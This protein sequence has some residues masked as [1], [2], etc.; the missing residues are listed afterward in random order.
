MTQ[1][2]F[3]CSN[4][5]EVLI[6]RCGAIVEDLGKARDR[7]ASVVRS[8]TTARSREDWRRWILHVNDD[9]GEELF[10]VLFAFILRKPS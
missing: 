8:L 9:L 1:V 2:Y 4:A 5:N 7:A 10:V 3:H 6:D